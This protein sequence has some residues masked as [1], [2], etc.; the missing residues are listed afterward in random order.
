MISG[1][2]SVGLLLLFVGGWI[3]AWRPERKAEFDAA[4]Q[5]PLSDEWDEDSLI[6]ASQS[7]SPIKEPLS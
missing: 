4:A 7:A 5:L 2:I 3:W 1:I 6:P